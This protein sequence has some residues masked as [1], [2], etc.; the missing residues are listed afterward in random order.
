MKNIILISCVSKKVQEKTSAE[1]IYISSLFEKNLRY[2]KSLQPDLIL[3]LSAKHGVLQL[4]QEIQPYDMTL[5]TMPKKEVEVWAKKV[6]EQLKEIANIKEDKFIFLAGNNYRKYLLPEISNYEIPMEGLPIGKQLQ[7]LT[8]NLKDSKNERIHKLFHTCKHHSFPYNED[9]IPKNG[10]YILFEKG[11]FAYGG[12]RIV[13][14]GT[15]TGKD[16]LQSRIKQ[17]FLSKN[18]DRSIFRKN[19]GRAILNKNGDSFLEQWEWDL[20][21]RANKSKYLDFLDKEKQDFIENQVTKYMQEN[22]SFAVFKV[23]NKE[24][25]LLLESR[26]ISTVSNS[27]ASKGS[28]NWLGNYSPKE[29]IRK[30]GLWLVN[31]LWKKSITDEELIHLTT[32]VKESSL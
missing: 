16:Q 14:I 6:L 3:I 8:A 18:K 22:L 12:K 29:K 17:H 9:E 19:I 28:E 5:N 23:D 26:I 20:T 31:E 25:R 2:A 4:H 27:D 1:N 10:I 32:L 13:R 21:T 11:E 24:D 30:S 7:W 15:H